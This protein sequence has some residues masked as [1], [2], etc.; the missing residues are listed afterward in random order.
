MTTALPAPDTTEQV[1]AV[2]HAARVHRE[3][4]EQHSTLHPDVWQAL[5]RSPIPKASL[6]AHCGGLEWDVPRIVDVVRTLA[7][8]DPS[9]GWA[10]AIHAPAGAF[11]ARLDE[12]AAHTVCA[13]SD[14]LPPLIAGSSLPAGTA[15][16]GNGTVRLCGRWPLV[17]SA[18]HMTVAALAAPCPKDGE[19]RW[20]F[21]P[22]SALTVA[23]DWNAVGL[24]GSASCSVACDARV[25]AEHSVRLT[26]PARLDAPLYRFPLYALMASC[27]A[28]VAHATAQRA[29]DAFEE[30]AQT[31]RPRHASASLAHLEPTQETYAQASAQISAAAA[32]ADTALTSAWSH[33]VRG[34]VPGSER[35]RLRAACSHLTQTSATVCRELFE[36]A[37]TAAIHRSHP[38]EGCWRDATV[39]ARH[40]LVAARGHQ[41]AGAQMLTGT[42]AKDL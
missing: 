27:I 8:A 23:E 39:A 24:R 33:A 21:V 41:L 3:Y 31:T 15:E 25:P 19:T 16:V 26:D 30:M 18:P 9:A 1:E 6:P 10:G 13:T 2:C 20:W 17:T 32:F 36:A 22:R 11:T 40:A 4:G 12:D 28:A 35:A 5:R 29:I 37:G 7:L 38:L 42:A 14:G 34:T